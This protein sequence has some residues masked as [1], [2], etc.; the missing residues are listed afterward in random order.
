MSV[1]SMYYTN[2]SF[3]WPLSFLTV[4]ISYFD[5]VHYSSDTA[6]SCF[7]CRERVMFGIFSTHRHALDQMGSGKFEIVM[8]CCITSLLAVLVVLCDS[9]FS[10]LGKFIKYF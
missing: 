3:S 5:A 9:N 1:I 7:Y 10:N 8:W 4:H 2:L 6:K